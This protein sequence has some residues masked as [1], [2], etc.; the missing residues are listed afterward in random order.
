MIQ[1]TNLADESGNDDDGF[2]ADGTGFG[3]PDSSRQ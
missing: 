1:K 3:S 2:T